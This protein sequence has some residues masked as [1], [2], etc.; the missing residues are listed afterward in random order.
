M[1]GVSTPPMLNFRIGNEVLDL[2][3]CPYGP[4]AAAQLRNEPSNLGDRLLPADRAPGP[5]MPLSDFCTAHDLS[6]DILQ[7]LSDH[8]VRQLLP[9]L[10]CNYTRA[11][12]D[13]V[14]VRRDSSASLRN[15]PF[16][17]NLPYMLLSTS[18][19]AMNCAARFVCV[20]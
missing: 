18:S 5:T 13:A 8:K 14:R 2:V 7:K 10:F 19:I 6:A 9:P 20:N 16:N 1:A 17:C 4:P 11:Q 3:R 12:A 15:G